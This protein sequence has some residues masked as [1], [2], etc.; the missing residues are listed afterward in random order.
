M[1]DPGYAISLQPGYVLV[2]DGQDYEVVWAEQPAKLRAISAACAEADCRKVLIRG[3]NA[4]VALTT[5]QMFDLGKEVGKLNLKIAV[6]TAHDT[7]PGDESLLENVAANRG[8]RVRFFDDE[9]GALIWL[10]L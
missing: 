4:N 10:G 6:V 1:S 5:S 7:T 3:S 2:E 8:S 9:Q